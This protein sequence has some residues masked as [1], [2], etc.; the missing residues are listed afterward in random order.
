MD[1][2]TRRNQER[3]TELRLRVLSLEQ[4]VEALKASTKSVPPARA[5]YGM[6]ELSVR[7]P[8]DVVRSIYLDAL[9]RERH[10]DTD[11]ALKRKVVEHFLHKQ[12]WSIAPHVTLDRVPSTTDPLGGFDITATLLLGMPT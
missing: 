11:E 3:L 8:A 6:T 12:F 5:G 1:D 4:E 10:S 7:L 9:T 2:E